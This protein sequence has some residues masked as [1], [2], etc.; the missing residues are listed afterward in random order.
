MAKKFSP[1]PG[2]EILFDRRVTVEV[3]A[4]KSGRVVKIEDDAPEILVVAIGSATMYFER[5]GNVWRDMSGDA[6]EVV[7]EI[8]DELE[9]ADEA[10]RAP[11][12]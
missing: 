11:K 1:A 12:F 7:G 6:P 2:V 10:K 3:K 4:P 5:Q 9:S 8:I